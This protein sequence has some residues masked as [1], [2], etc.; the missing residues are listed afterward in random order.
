M[1]VCATSRGG[2]KRIQPVEQAMPGNDSEEEM[3]LRLAIQLS[4]EQAAEENKIR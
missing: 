2:G 4:N 3:Q 1:S